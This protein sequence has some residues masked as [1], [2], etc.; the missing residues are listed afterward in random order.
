MAHT[1][2]V[3]AQSRYR[4]P[5]LVASIVTH[6]NLNCKG[7]GHFA[8]IAWKHN[9]DS[10]EFGKDMLR[11]ADLFKVGCVA[12]RGGEPLLHPD[13][14]DILHMTRIAFDKSKIELVT[15]GI[16][17]ENQNVKFWRTCD[18]LNI[19]VVVS[20]YGIAGVS[21]IATQQADKYGVDLQYNENNTLRKVTLDLCGN[22][23]PT[24][25]WKDCYYDGSFPMVL[26]GK[27]Y[28]CIIMPNT[29]HLC[30][31]FGLSMDM[32]EM[33]YLNIYSNLSHRDLTTYIKSPKQFCRFCKPTRE[34]L[35]YEWERSNFEIGEWT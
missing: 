11:M 17:L 27:F 28:P 33:D 15:N 24:K 31:K 19:K 9:V 23:I 16:L 26:E 13:L 20:G 32:R 35:R 21:T 18:S 14:L 5:Y 8:P 12:I 3:V 10:L 25:S 34:P 7:C 6:C 1:D 30:R 4:L 29:V 22:Q 2:K